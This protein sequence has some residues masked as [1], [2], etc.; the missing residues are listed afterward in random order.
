MRRIL[1]SAVLAVGLLAGCGPEFQ[2]PSSPQRV[3]TPLTTTDVDVPSECQGILDFVNNASFATLDYYLPSDVAT[4]IV[5]RRAVTPI[6]SIADLSSI[7]L[8]GETRLNQIFSGSVAEGYTGASCL[9]IFDE[10]AFSTDD[11]AKLVNLVN[12]ITDQEMHDILPYG[13]NGAVNLLTLRPFTS[14]AAISGTSGIGVVGLRNLRNAATL[15]GPLETLA[16]AVN[17]TQQGNGGALMERHFNWY[18]RL[19]NSG[20]YQQ[21]SA[22]C[23]GIDPTNAPWGA[24]IRANLADAAEVHQE[25]AGTVSFANRYNQISSQVIPDGLANLDA[26][27]AGR[28]FFGCYY[29][30]AN[31]PWSGHN[32]AFFVDTVNGFGVWTETYWVE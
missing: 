8:V 3:Q 1:S 5:N 31:D 11:Q 17:A 19:N 10:L 7:R 24:E 29:S 14:V 4:N 26:R 13:W 9:G 22:T 28:T 16:A 30:Y 25:V 6:V 20:Y 2:Q 27:A 12:T 15:S 18:D 21:T 23:F 32:A